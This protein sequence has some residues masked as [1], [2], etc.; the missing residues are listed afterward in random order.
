M[1]FRHKFISHQKKLVYYFIHFISFIDLLITLKNRKP[2]KGIFHRDFFIL[3]LR[4]NTLA[5]CCL[6]NF[7]FI[8]LHT[9]RF[10]KDIIL[11]FLSLQLFDFYFLQFFYTLKNN[12][13]T[14]LYKQ[15]K[16]FGK[17]IKSLN[18]YF[19]LHFR[20]FFQHIIY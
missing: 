11:P 3:K 6:I 12:T 15:N 1:H 4:N 16:I 20:I 2:T 9:T 10:D 17:L 7:D 5:S 13:I 8:L 19:F 18:F 14:L